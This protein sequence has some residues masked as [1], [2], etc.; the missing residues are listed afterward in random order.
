MSIK[1]NDSCFR[2]SSH[3]KCQSSTLAE[4]RLDVYDHISYVKDKQSGIIGGSEPGG[5]M[6]CRV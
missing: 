6:P 5:L 3:S 1:Y 2:G 4:A